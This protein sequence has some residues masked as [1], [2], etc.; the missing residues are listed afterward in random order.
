MTIEPATALESWRI[1]SGMTHANRAVFQ[2]LSANTAA[3][4]DMR[5]RSEASLAILATVLIAAV[6]LRDRLQERIVEAGGR[7]L[8]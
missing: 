7:Q 5:G 4:E 1:C 3:D 6:T 8:Q 2:A